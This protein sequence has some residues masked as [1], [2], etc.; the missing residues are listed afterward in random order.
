M[1]KLLEEIWEGIPESDG[2]YSI[3]SFGRVKSQKRSSS[4]ILQPLKRKD[5]YLKVNLYLNGN[6]VN[7]L[8]NNVTNNCSTNL[9]WC[10][11]LSNNQHT[12]KQNRNFVPSHN[13]LDAITIAEIKKLHINGFSGRAIAKQLKISRES[14]KRHI[15]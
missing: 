4:K 11:R 5:G 9:E 7:H 14:V 15:D 8:D 1:S 3:S 2:H 12:V 6:I 13:R 10:S